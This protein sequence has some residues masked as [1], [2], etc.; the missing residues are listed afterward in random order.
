MAE[1]PR[2][3]ADRLGR[4][5]RPRRR[6]GEAAPEAPALLPPPLDAWLA[7]IESLAALLE[8][9]AEALIAGRA[10]R[11]AEF[12]RRKH[13]AEAAV[14]D[15]ARRAVA[16]GLALDKDSPHAARAAAA[17]AALERAG[18]R[19]AEALAA[20]HD[21]VSYVAG[22]VKKSLTETRAEGMYGRSGRAVA[23]YDRTVAGL[24]E[25]Y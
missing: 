11:L 12:I 24:D 21:A 19:N 20:A 25:A 9:E 22:L 1:A 7:A 6:R 5:D 10:E 4:L 2:R 8:E 14:K 3:L 13:E 18:Q 15:S 16:A 17:I 23:G